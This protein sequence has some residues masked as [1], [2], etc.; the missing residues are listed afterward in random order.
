ML[1]TITENIVDWAVCEWQVCGVT[2]VINKII[3]SQN[4]HHVSGF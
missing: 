2:V 1:I 4:K 3:E